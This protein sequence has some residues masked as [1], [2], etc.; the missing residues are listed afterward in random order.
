MRGV[1]TAIACLPAGLALSG[2]ARGYVPVAHGDAVTP[3]HS[4]HA[5]PRRH[6]APP[7]AALRPCNSVLAGERWL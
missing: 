2:C 6:V 1:R 5:G 3:P 7:G 4:H